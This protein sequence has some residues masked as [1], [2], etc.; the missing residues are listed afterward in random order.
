MHIVRTGSC[1]FCSNEAGRH[2]DARKHFMSRVLSTGR[3]VTIMAKVSKE[4]F[5]IQNVNFVH[6]DKL[7]AFAVL[8][9]M[10]TYVL[11]TYEYS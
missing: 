4:I 6:C 3:V 9:K 10:R 11:I 5:L 1:A 8:L 2:P 7:F